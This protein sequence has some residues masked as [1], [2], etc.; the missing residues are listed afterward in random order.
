MS[1]LDVFSLYPST[2][3]DVGEMKNMWGKGGIHGFQAHLDVSNAREDY[4]K[5]KSRKNMLKLACKMYVDRNHKKIYPEE[6]V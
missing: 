1:D 5:D 2:M 4:Q 6:Y 3:K